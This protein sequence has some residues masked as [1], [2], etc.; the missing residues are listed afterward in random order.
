M[1]KALKVG[2]LITAVL[3]SAASAHAASVSLYNDTDLAGGT[4]T[5]RGTVTCDDCTALS[6]DGFGYSFASP[7]E[8]F[9]GPSNSGDANEIA[10]VNAVLASSYTTSDMIDYTDNASDGVS[11][12]IDAQYVILKSGKKPSYTIL[13]NADSSTSFTFAYDGEKASGL[14]HFF[15]VGGLT[16]GGGVITP[17][18]VPVPASLPLMALGLGALGFLRHRK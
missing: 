8:V 7:G 18:E 10:W 15:G 5:L 11:Y 16:T 9:Y 14:S 3:F 4:A 2:G 13:Q 1:I 17:P 6:Y 12:T